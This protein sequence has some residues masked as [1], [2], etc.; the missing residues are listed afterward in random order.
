MSNWWKKWLF[1]TLLGGSCIAALGALILIGRLA[2]GI[3]APS[4][5]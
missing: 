2:L 5:P 4:E 1:R 3:E